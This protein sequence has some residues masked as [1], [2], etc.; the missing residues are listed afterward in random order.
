[1]N[2][3]LTEALNRQV[4]KEMFSWYLYKSMSAYFDSI[5]Y[6][7]FATWMSQQAMEEMIHAEKIYKYIIDRGGRVELELIEKPQIEWDSPLAAM[8]DALEHEKYITKSINELV[9]LAI[10]ENDHGTNVFL[11]WFVQEQIEEESSVGEI[12][13]RIR[14]FGE[15]KGGLFMLD[16]ELGTRTE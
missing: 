12:V 7:G 6:R 1:M 8:E 10:A 4:N 15:F 14:M 5:N 16:R 13:E 11:H 3:K 2:Q 9:D